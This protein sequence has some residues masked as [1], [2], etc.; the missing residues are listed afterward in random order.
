M[1]DS[2]LT[3]LISKAEKELVLIDNYVDIS[4]LNILAKIVAEILEKLK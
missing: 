3:E 2:D 1:L 4:T